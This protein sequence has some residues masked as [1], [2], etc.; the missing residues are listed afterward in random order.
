MKT[1]N[2][3]PT[4][5][6]QTS[7]FLLAQIHELQAENNQLNQEN[8][9]LNQENNQLNQDLQ[10]QQNHVDTLQEQLRLM[11][12]KLYARKSEQALVDERQLNLFEEEID[13]V[14]PP[15]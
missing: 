1:Q 6:S 12:L 13:T 5:R 4:S 14:Q 15:L 2:T 11:G 8:N 9:Q 7:G 3:P 10:K